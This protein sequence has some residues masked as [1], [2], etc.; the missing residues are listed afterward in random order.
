M[1]PSSVFLF[2]KNRLDKNLQAPFYLVSVTAC[3]PNEIVCHC[4]LKLLLRD[5]LI[6][7]AKNSNGYFIIPK[8]GTKTFPMPLPL[9]INKRK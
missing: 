6:S 7:N 3:L 5:L 4:Y 9:I 8:F 2:F 1:E